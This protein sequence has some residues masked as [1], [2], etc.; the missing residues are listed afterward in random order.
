MPRIGGADR[1]RGVEWS[2]RVVAPPV[3]DAIGSVGALLH[4]PD[5]EAR[6]QRMEAPGRHVEHIA[7]THS[8]PRQQWGD[9]GARGQRARDVGAGD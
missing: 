9:V 8:V 1:L 6:H 3:G 4:L 2:R 5:E 7:T